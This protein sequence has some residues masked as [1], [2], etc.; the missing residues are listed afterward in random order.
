MIVS[1]MYFTKAQ[2]IESIW[3]T[4]TFWKIADFPFLERFEFMGISIWL[5]NVLNSVCLLIWAGTRGLKQLF[6]V[7]QK[8]SL[9]V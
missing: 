1:L 7:K 8:H 4:L 3:P 9:I 5:F 2:L 6:T